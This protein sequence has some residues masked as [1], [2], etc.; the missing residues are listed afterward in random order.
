MAVVGPMRLAKVPPSFAR[1][2]AAHDQGIEQVMT[3]LL[4]GLTG[5]AQQQ[6]VA[7]RVATLPMK[8]GGLASVQPAEWHQQHIGRHGRTRCHDRLEVARNVDFSS[9]CCPSTPDFTPGPDVLFQID[10]TTLGLVCP[11]VS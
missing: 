6:D 5:D 9:F 11:S 10:P 7:R 4:E 1:E 8:M 3:T 2:H